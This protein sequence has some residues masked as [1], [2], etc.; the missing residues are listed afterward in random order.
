MAYRIAQGSTHNQADI[1]AFLERLNHLNQ[2]AAPEIRDLFTPYGE[3]FVARAP[4]RLDVMG[5]IADYSGSLVLQLPLHEAALVAVQRQSA[6]EVHIISL[7]ADRK[8]RATFYP[9]AKTIGTGSL[10]YQVAREYFKRNSEQH[11]A[12]YVVGAFVVL[13]QERGVNFPQGA[14][15]LIASHVPEGKGVSSSAALE[16]AVMQAVTAAF[17]ITLEAREMA[18]LCQKV[19]NLVAGAPCGIMDQMASACGVENRLLA[20]LCQ[21]AELKEM[22]ALPEEITVWGLDSG[23]RHSVG[24]QAHTGADYGSVRTGAFMGYRMIAELAGLKM[25]TGAPGKPVHIDDPRWGGYLANLTPTEFEQQYA[26][27][28]PEHISGAAFLER[29]GSTTDPITQVQP[30]RTYAVRI[31]TAHPIYENARV[32]EFASTLNSWGTQ[33]PETALMR[34]GELMYQSHASYSACGLGSTATDRIVEL[35]RAAGPT[36]G[37]YGAKITG[38][39]SGGTVAVLGHRGADAAVASIAAQYEKETGHRPHIFAGSSPG[40][41]AF[42]YLKLTP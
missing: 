37:L 12:A 7:G 40:A 10:S 36:Q 32:Q 35:V 9:L 29:Y 27:H 22:V 16:V 33:K 25:E 11:W 1:A 41:A 34:L 3:L 26:P 21:P 14:R 5:G 42:G 28:L 39:G 13:H 15:I 20:L 6:L 18:I 8:H 24:G 17:E 23:V 4:G 31:P 19:E 38:G 30:E 2:D